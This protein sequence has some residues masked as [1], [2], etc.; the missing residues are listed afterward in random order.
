MDLGVL[1]ML[2]RFGIGGGVECEDD[3]VEG[4]SANKL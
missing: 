3:A 2:V 1:G 4:D